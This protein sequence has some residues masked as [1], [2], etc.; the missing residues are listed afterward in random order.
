MA[1]SDISR[2]AIII[3]EY[4]YILSHFEGYSKIL[5]FI[6]SYTTEYDRPTQTDKVLYDILHRHIQVTF[7]YYSFF[8]TASNIKIFD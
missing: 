7:S 2:N 6:V 8:S 1:V 3:N 4:I 5:S